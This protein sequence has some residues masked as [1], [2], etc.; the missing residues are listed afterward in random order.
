MAELKVQRIDAIL[1]ALKPTMENLTKYSSV[2]LTIRA[3][4]AGGQPTG[5]SP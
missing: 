1:E 2:V 5:K 4:M 3:P